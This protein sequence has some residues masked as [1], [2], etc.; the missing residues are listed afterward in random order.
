MDKRDLK[1]DL[2]LCNR[3]TIGPWK[4]RTYCDYP[5]VILRDNLDEERDVYPEVMA[6]YSTD[7]DAHFIA[8]AREGW[9]YAI[10]KVHEQEI[11]MGTMKMAYA[12][13]KDRLEE[14]EALVR[15]LVEALEEALIMANTMF[16]TDAYD[17]MEIGVKATLDKAK[18]VLRDDN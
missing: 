9:P 6:L 16:Y 11:I 1:A 10:R 17:Q 12:D 13:Q 4:V 3:A 7:K 8:Q 2:E 5:F 14:L 15:E 18:E